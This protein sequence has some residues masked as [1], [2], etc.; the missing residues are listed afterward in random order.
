MSFAHLHAEAY[1]AN[2]RKLS[3]IELIGFSDTDQERG[4]HFSEVF[5]TKCFQSHEGLLDAKP[6]AVIICSENAN[7]REHVVMA[8]REGVH[9]LCEKPIA[10]SLEDAKIMRDACQKA[11]VNF[12]TA[13]PMR[14]DPSIIVVKEM[15]EQGKLGKLYAVNGINHSELP[16]KH[17]LWFTQKA[18]AG[19]GAVMDHTVHLVDLLRWYTGHEITE[20]YAEI[21]N[22]LYPGEVDVETVGLVTVTFENGVFASID[23]SW[24]RPNNYPRWGHLQMEL[25]GEKGAVSVDAFAQYL[26][27]YSE[28]APR[29]PSWSAWGA[30]PNQTMIEEFIASIKE[31]REPRVSWSD[32]FAALKVALACYESAQRK[33]PIRLKDFK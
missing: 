26:T 3:D 10:V 14:F 25:I 15:L 7:H 6:D 11:G 1:I 29:D 33:E 23:C 13:F 5:K 4:E 12:M 30:D 27:V 32:G 9:V 28:L 22:V 18:L 17:R 8:A 16:K 24:S 31:K 20:V 21:S 2:I 19:G